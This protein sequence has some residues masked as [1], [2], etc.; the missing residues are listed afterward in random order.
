LIEK[1]SLIDWKSIDEKIRIDIVHNNGAI[2]Q[3]GND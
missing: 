2:G 3:S 1:Y